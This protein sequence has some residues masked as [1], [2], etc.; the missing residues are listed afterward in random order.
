MIFSWVERNGN[1]RNDLDEKLLQ[2]FVGEFFN[3]VMKR[4]TVILNAVKAHSF[5][6]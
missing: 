1:Q 6:F 5:K 3:E 2:S 4:N